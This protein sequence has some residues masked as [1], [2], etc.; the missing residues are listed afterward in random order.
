M[1]WDHEKGARFLAQCPCCMEKRRHTAFRKTPKKQRDCL[2]V[3]WL[4]WR[5]SYCCCLRCLVFFISIPL[6]RTALS[7]FFFAFTLPN[8]CVFYRGHIV[9][10]STHVAA[11]LGPGARSQR[12]R[13]RE[14]RFLA[15]WI[16]FAITCNVGRLNLTR[17]D[18]CFIVL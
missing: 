3:G 2:M 14:N 10:N 7:E 12:P 9:S 11:H 15:W 17:R 1:A 6:C 16:V 4:G 8:C 18:H 13:R 5:W